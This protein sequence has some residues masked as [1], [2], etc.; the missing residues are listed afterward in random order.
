MTSEPSAAALN[1]DIRVEAVSSL[2]ALREEWE[3]VAEA[4]GNVFSSWEWASTWW[5]HFGED[6][7]LLL[8]ACRA[9]DG[10]LAAVLP[11]YLWSTRPV[12][13][14]RFLG[15]GPADQLGPVCAPADRGWAARALVRACSEAGVD[16]LLAELLPGGQRWPS[17]LG[18]TLIQREASPTL[19]LAG[20]WDAY[21][22]GRS[23]NFRQQVRGRERRLA[24]SHKLRFRLAA[25]PARLQEDI[26]LLFSLHAARWGE[27]SAFV[28]WA[29]FHRVFAAVA[30]ERGWLR[31]WFLELDGRPA[32]AWYGFRF[33]DV[34]SYYQAGRDPGRSDDSVGFVL[35][36]HSIREAAADG[37]REYR[38][39]RGAEPFKLRFAD[40]DPGLETVALAR[41]LAGTVAGLAAAAGVR[42]G[43]I[44][45]ALRR[46]GH[47]VT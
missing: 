6:G 13:V 11:L 22:A 40:S 43:A 8:F 21:L 36:A 47:S 33:G 9:A 3:W 2:D 5:Q 39:L 23:A 14:A 46:L 4:N 27:R 12:R 38:F 7:R 17:A 30:L 15:H 29:A 42:S 24:R 25:D 20:G 10:R 34:E 44:R 31:L 45:S 26:D 35:L 18:G 37:M 1:D 32:A 28:R 16:L 19:S 41:G